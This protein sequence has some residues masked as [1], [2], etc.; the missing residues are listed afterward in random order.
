MRGTGAVVG[1]ALVMLHVV[2]PDGPLRDDLYLVIGAASVGAVLWGIH[3]HR[4]SAVTPW[5]LMAAGQALWVL[6]DFMYDEPSSGSATWAKAMYLAAYPLLALGIAELIRSHRHAVDVARIVDSA[7]VTLGAFLLSWVF[8]VDPIVDDTSRSVTAR[9]VAAAY[10][11]GDVLLLAMIVTLVGVPGVRSTSYRLLTASIVLLVVADTWYAAIPSSSSRLLDALWLVSYVAWGLAALDPSMT[12]LIDTPHHRRPALSRRRLATLAATALVAPALVVAQ[13]VHGLHVDT[14]IVVVG[15]SVL[16]VLAI[17]RVALDLDELRRT[18]HQ[19]EQLERRLLHETSHDSA[20]GLLNATAFRAVVGSALRRGRHERTAVAVLL[21]TVDAY[22]RVVDVHGSAAG[23]V[24]LDTVA[25][26][27][28]RCAADADRVGRLGPELLAV[29]V[30]P[31]RSDTEVRELAARVVRSLAAPVLVDGTDIVVS[32]CVGVAT[33]TAGDTRSDELTE[34]AHVALRRARATGWGT[35]EVFSHGLR[36]E[37]DERRALEEELQRA[38]DQGELELHYQPILS[39]QSRFVDG[40]EARVHWRRPGHGWQDSREL[41][42]VAALS[43]LVCRIDRWTVTTAVRHLA[44][45]TALD[46]VR[47]GDLTVAVTVSG[48]TL[49]SPGFVDTVTDTLHDSGVEPHRLTIGVTEMTLVDTPRA[50]VALRTLRDREVFVSI[51]EFGTGHTPITQ[52]GRLPAD[53]IKVDPSLVNSTDPS[54]RDMLAL[55]ANV[56]H[57]CGLLAVAEGVTDAGHLDDLRAMQYD[58]AQGLHSSTTDPAASGVTVVQS[59]G[60][61][62]HLRVVPDPDD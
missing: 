56:A 24:V 43:D 44:T 51:N 13:L 54:A 17:A 10:P 46:P 16:S 62:G 48:R 26:R 12:R 45:W 14:W 52:L 39:V 9:A 60:G 30:Y 50:E 29:C 42:A 6:G 41:L 32:A 55:L 31:A 7:V 23:D 22:D 38:L 40:Y 11:V 59:V 25:S 49:S 27:L 2:L 3:R 1:G 35:L 21:V 8:L 34:Q 37:E 19:C 61:R 36:R 33:S 58:S 28:R 18:A 4:P 5:L 20:T 53:I 15:A 47:F 57:G